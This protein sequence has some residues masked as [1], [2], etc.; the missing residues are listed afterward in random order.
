MRHKF[1]LPQHVAEMI[2]RASMPQIRRT[3]EET[4]IGLLQ[5]RIQPDEADAILMLAEEQIL[6]LEQEASNPPVERPQ[7]QDRFRRW[8]N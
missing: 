6:T 7:G 4:F 3:L 5:G 8:V 1:K 2:A